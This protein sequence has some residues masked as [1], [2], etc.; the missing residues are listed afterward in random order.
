MSGAASAA[1]GDSCRCCRDEDDRTVRAGAFD[2]RLA[3]ELFTMR[4]ARCARN[5]WRSSV[6]SACRGCAIARIGTGGARAR[7]RE[8][9]P[10]AAGE[11]DD[12]R[13]PDPP[14]P[15]GVAA[16]RVPHVPGCRAHRLRRKWTRG[17]KRRREAEVLERV[18][19]L[20]VRAVRAAGEVLPRAVKRTRRFAGAAALTASET[21]T[22]VRPARSTTSR[23]ASCRCGGRRARAR[24]R[25]ASS[26]R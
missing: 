12:V 24:R 20:Q 23:R 7:R 26:T 17:T 14:L 11:E 15:F 13:R 21:A 22:S 6:G 2:H 16:I 10:V 8:D 25:R 4:I 3:D 19:D 9:R 1:A 18:A 5:A